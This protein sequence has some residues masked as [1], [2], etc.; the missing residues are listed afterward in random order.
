[1]FLDPDL[2]N[3]RQ[4]DAQPRIVDLLLGAPALIA[5]LSFD[6]AVFHRFDFVAARERLPGI[7]APALEDDVRIHQ[8]GAAVTRHRALMIL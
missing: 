8:D 2:V 5:R 7:N 1:M 4:R 3:R 6:H